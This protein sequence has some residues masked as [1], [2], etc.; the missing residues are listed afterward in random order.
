MLRLL[1][2]ALLL[3][4]LLALVKRFFPGK[5]PGPDEPRI[6]KMVRCDYCQI[7]IP[8][9]SAIKHADRYYCCDEHRES[10]S[11]NAS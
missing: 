4:L 5:P 6:A 7:Y 9:T 3:V 1:I 2:I 11:G 10:A 8:H